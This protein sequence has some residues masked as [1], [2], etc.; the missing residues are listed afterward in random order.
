MKRFTTIL[1]SVAF[2]VSGFMISFMKIDPQNQLHAAPIAPIVL[3]SRAL[4]L[5]L[6]LD[7]AKYDSINSRVDT[8]IRHDTVRVVKYK[9]K[10]RAPKKAVEPDSLLAPAIKDTLYVPKLK[11]F[12]QMGKDV[13]MD[14]TFIRKPDS[15][16]CP[17]MQPLRECEE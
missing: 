17:K 15:I 16:E 3:S 2:V 1:L 6:Q 14:T 10:Y 11:I 7:L 9:T 8:I 13:L 12:I 4:P 5:D